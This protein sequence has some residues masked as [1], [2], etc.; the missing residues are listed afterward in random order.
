MNRFEQNYYN[1][2]SSIEKSLKRIANALENNNKED[3]IYYKT[4]KDMFADNPCTKEEYDAA[5]QDRI[6]EQEELDAQHDYLHQL[7]KNLSGKDYAE[8]CN[9]HCLPTADA[10]AVS[11]YIT[12]LDYD[13]VL[14]IISDL[15]SSNDLSIRYK[16]K[17]KEFPKSDDQANEDAIELDFNIDPIQAGDY[18]RR[19]PLHLAS[20]E[21]HLEVVEF[22]LDHGVQPIADRWG[23]FPIA[24]AQNNN[25]QKI[26]DVFDRLPIAYTQ[27]VHLV[28]NIHGKTDQMATFDD[29]L[30]VIELL[31]AAAE[32]NVN[33]IRQLVAKG[34]PVHAG[35]YDSRTA[36]HLAAAEG[37]LA[38]VHYLVTHGHP[39]Y[40]RDRWGATPYDE[41]KRENRLTVMQYLNKLMD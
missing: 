39:L 33:G 26:V 1:D 34:V 11:N 12:D 17:I 36:L 2:I 10:V 15:E 5:K 37:S 7:V 25:H 30:M 23:G 27:P 38:A 6:Q 19:T 24:D 29:E 16:N 40:I 31:F 22:L 35:D 32:N 20:A 21:G 4:R 18:D 41:A 14:G 13:E 9:E 8:F 28:E 3:K